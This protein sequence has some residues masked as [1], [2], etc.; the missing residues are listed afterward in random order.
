MNTSPG[1]SRAVFDVVVERLGWVLVAFAVAVHF[2]RIVC[3]H[4]I[5]RHAA[6]HG[7]DALCALACLWTFSMVLRIATW[8]RQRSQ[9]ATVAATRLVTVGNLIR[10]TPNR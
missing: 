8:T 6:K 1:S 3:F 2:G 10:I 5:K 7:R 9:P 4:P